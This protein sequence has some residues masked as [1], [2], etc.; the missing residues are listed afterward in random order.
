[1]EALRALRERLRAASRRN[2]PVGLEEA[3]E[4]VARHFV[5]LAGYETAVF[6]RRLVPRAGRVLVVG[7]GTGRDWWYLRLDNDVVGLDLVEQSTVPEVV[8]ADLS[9]RIPFEDG[10]FAAVVISDVLE[11]VFRDL[12]ALRESRRVLA[13]AGVL[14]VNLPYGDDIGDHHV[15]VYTRATA[16]RLLEAAGFRVVEEIER[17]PLAH[18]DRYAPWRALF[19]GA[20]L[21]RFL[22]TGDPG[23]DR[24]LRWLVAIDWFFGR[25]RI[26]PGRWSKR[27]GA[28]LRAVKAPVRD[29]A[30]INREWYR[31]QGQAQMSRS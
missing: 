13:P 28:Y 8:I 31:D 25:R 21:A 19:H 4:A 18:L 30:A 2:L 12:D 6:L 24:T 11:H 27:H 15:R 7:V 14:V 22:M 5:N 9:E 23:Y 26:S 29:F 20:H 16:R 17:G 1:M 10:T 3:P